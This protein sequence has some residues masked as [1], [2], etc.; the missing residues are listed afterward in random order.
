MLPDSL[1]LK[2]ASFANKD[3]IMSVILL[4]EFT[5]FSFAAINSNYVNCDYITWEEKPSTPPCYITWSTYFYN[6]A[7]YIVF[8]QSARVR[9]NVKLT[10][11]TCKSCSS[12]VKSS[13]HSRSPHYTCRIVCS[14]WSNG[15]VCLQPF[16]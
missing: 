8:L 10:T 1:T 15:S 2:G 5:L 13:Q 12:R 4:P 11:C 3:T 6:N 9:E 14:F 16:I 7:P